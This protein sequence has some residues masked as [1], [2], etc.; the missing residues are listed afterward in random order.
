MN[1]PRRRWVKKK[2]K[3]TIDDAKNNR[4]RRTRGNKGSQRSWW[5][6]GPKPKVEKPVQLPA[7]EV[8]HGI[9]ESPSISS[10]SAG[11]ETL[12][13]MLVTPRMTWREEKTQ[14]ASVSRIVREYLPHLL[15]VRRVNF[16]EYLGFNVSIFAM[17]FDEVTGNLYVAGQ[18]PVFCLSTDGSGGYLWG[19]NWSRYNIDRSEDA[20]TI[21][22]L[23]VGPNRTL[24]VCLQNTF[25]SETK[26]IVAIP[27]PSS[28]PKDKEQKE[29]K[30]HEKCY[31]VIGHDWNLVDDRVCSHPRSVTTRR[32]RKTGETLL[33]I[34]DD[35]GIYEM[36]ETVIPLREDQGVLHTWSVTRIVWD[37]AGLYVVRSAVYNTGS[38]K[39][40]EEYLFAL[41]GSKSTSE[42]HRIH[43]PSDPPRKR[44]SIGSPRISPTLIDIKE[45]KCV[46]AS[47]DEEISET[48]EGRLVSSSVPGIATH[49]AP[50][51]TPDNAWLR[52]DRELLTVSRHFSEPDSKTPVVSSVWR[53]KQLVIDVSPIAFDLANGALWLETDSNC[54]TKFVVL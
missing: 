3:N 6:K 37:R 52:T 46:K 26:R 33:Y 47:E 12:A 39:G 5:R 22:D 53:H 35:N 38:K 7:H 41:G 14:W 54:Y 20:L 48:S 28:S 29:E 9:S 51:D 50:G 16:R 32:S 2:A 19:S 21:T 49:L 10:G 36:A 45:N 27:L 17:A 11:W 1:R 42:I 31:T 8:Q 13:W 44:S 25:V 34:A 15:P 30:K 40:T 4:S 18:F 24:F 23:A 43:I